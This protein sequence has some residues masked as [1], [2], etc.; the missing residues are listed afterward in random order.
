M[1]KLLPWVQ[2]E[3]LYGPTEAAI[4]V[5]F[6]NCVTEN[7]EAVPIGRPIWNTRIYVLDQWLNPVPVGATGELYI[8]GAGL[9]RGYLRR[10]GLTAERFVADPFGPVGS[11]MY[12][13]GDLARWRS[14]GVLDFLGRSDFQVK[15]RGF[16]IEPAEI[17]AALARHLTVAQSAVIARDDKSGDK[18]LVAYVV[19]SKD[20]LQ[21]IRCNH[22]ADLRN[23]TVDQWKALFDETYAAGE[24]GKGPSFVGWNSSYTKTALPEEEMREWVTTTVERIAA[25]RANRV[26]EIGCGI[27][28]L[29]QHLAP[30]CQVYRGTDISSFAIAELKRW[31]TTQ[32]A[33]QHV[34][35]FQGQ[36]I[37]LDDMCSNEFDL[38]IL[39]SVVQYF[40][41]FDYLLAVLRKAINLV[42]SGGWVF[43]GDIRHS[44]LLSVFHT[45]VQLA[46]AS[47]RLTV[48]QLKDR[49]ALA[50]AQENEL[51]IDPEFFFA[52]QEYIPRIGSIEI[53]L[54]RGL[55]DNELTR[56][57]YDAVL[58][59]GKAPLIEPQEIIE[60]TSDNSLASISARLAERAPKSV[61]IC[62][63]PNRRLS[64]DLAAA[65][66]LA[67]SKDFRVVADLRQSLE[68]SE[69]SSIDPEAFGQLGVA[70]DY[71]TKIGWTTDSQTGCFDVLF[72]Q[73]GDVSNAV[74]HHHSPSDP[75]RPL[76]TYVSD[77]SLR[78]FRRQ[79]IFQLRKCSG[80]YYQITWFR[81]RLLFWNDFR[82]LTTAS[83]TAI[84]C[85]S[86]QAPA[87]TFSAV[88]LVMVTKRCSAAS[89]PN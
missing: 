82:L 61:R 88:P 43:V 62:N 11:R 77:P 3:N 66:I 1:L 21:D 38:V 70:Q 29:L 37:A 58:H 39:N 6:W 84:V 31:T 34:E 19:P 56:Y 73:R 52:L 44:K 76:N 10:A 78:G 32:Q 15:I 7:S 25:L 60:W 48:G 14:D 5:T 49:I 53:L 80:R 47:S 30:L 13:T 8:A 64:R 87:P 46:R 22:S 71:E 28:L 79:L 57:R 75:Q 55:S 69:N 67:T 85:Q 33:F 72:V 89:L 18:R 86:P 83:S 63:V 68:K 42:S 51:G 50:I 23:E 27:G 54:K 16:R 36:A 2:L 12:R 26:L 40:P 35:L 59:I 24:I 81:P 20:G 74:A 45:S 9:A 65:Q 17:E 41:D 4:D